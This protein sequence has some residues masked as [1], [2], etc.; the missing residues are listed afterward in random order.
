M[1]IFEM[2]FQFGLGIESNSADLAFFIFS[3]SGRW[4]ARVL[5]PDMKVFSPF[6]SEHPSGTIRTFK[7]LLTAVHS[8]MTEK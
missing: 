3:A 6:L 4:F 7:D 1:N 8:K 5:L 2:R